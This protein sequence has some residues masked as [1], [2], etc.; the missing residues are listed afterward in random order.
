MSGKQKR[1]LQSRLFSITSALYTLYSLRAFSLFF[2]IIS[3]KTEI[4]VLL[5]LNICIIQAFIWTNLYIAKLFNLSSIRICLQFLS[6][7]LLKVCNHRVNI[8]YF[9]Q[10]LMR[11]FFFC[12]RTVQIRDFSNQTTSSSRR[13]AYNTLLC[14]VGHLIKFEL[15]VRNKGE[16]TKAIFHR[17]WGK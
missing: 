13:Q 5:K 1:S 11:N 9:I 17:L 2:Y 8:P 12:S 15:C 3:I 4:L 16:S 7:L 14:A 6:Y 10:K